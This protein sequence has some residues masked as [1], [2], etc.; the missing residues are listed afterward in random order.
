[1]GETAHQ[2][3][4]REYGQM[5]DATSNYEEIYKLL[6]TLPAEEAQEILRRIRSGTPVETILTHVQAGNLLLRVAV[7]QET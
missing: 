3:L 2:A 4:K 5:K 1:M 6:Q 7:R